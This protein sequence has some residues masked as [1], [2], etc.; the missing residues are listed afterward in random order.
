MTQGKKLSRREREKLRQRQDIL[1]AALELFSQSGYHNVSMNEIAEKSEF[2]VGTLYN[3]FSN[4]EDIYNSLMV[5]ISNRFFNALMKALNE[6]RNEIEKLRNFVRTKGEVFM[7]NASVV[8]LYHA[9]T[10]G[11]CYNVKAG[12]DP[13]FRKRYDQV[14][15]EVAAVFERG[16]KKQLFKKIAEPYLLAV[17]LNGIIND[18]LFL[19]LEDSEKNPF[20]ENPDVILNI[21]FDGLLNESPKA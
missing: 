9:E 20:P 11:T 14:Q 4:K 13:D 6:G 8:R 5:E 3:F 17:A 18:F 16:I 21:L 15:Q 7:E 10:K 1:A 12:L 2:A 19:W